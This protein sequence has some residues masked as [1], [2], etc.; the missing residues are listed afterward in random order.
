MNWAR[1]VDALATL[2]AGADGKSD[3]VPYIEAV[4]TVVEELGALEGN[5]KCSLSIALITDALQSAPSDPGSDHI[6]HLLAR[7]AAELSQDAP[8]LEEG[9][10][11][12][13]P[14][15]P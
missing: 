7:L 5:P 15:C 11:V 13:L 14:C 3:G 9:S 8:R 1:V 2:H 12:H 4:R 6:V 10:A